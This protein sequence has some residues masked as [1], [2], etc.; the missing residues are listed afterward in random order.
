MNNAA[1]KHRLLAILAA[2]AAGYSRLMAEDA[3]ATVE[4]LELARGAF[5][6]QIQLGGGRVIDMAGDSVLAV[7]DTV[8]GAVSSA[9]E[10]QSELYGETGSDSD[11]RR[12]QF[13][14]GVHLSDV[15]EKDDG[16]VYGDGVNIASRLQALAEPGGIVVSQAVQ[17]EVLDRIDAVFMDL[18]EHGERTS[19]DLSGRTAQ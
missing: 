18:G 16:S 12:M 3:G 7:F 2:D 11:P 8:A 1:F 13:R 17:G 9:F 4:S 19:L 14:I 15:I 10:V 6:R 5:R